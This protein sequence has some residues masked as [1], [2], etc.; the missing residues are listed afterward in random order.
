[1]TSIYPG[2]TVE[3]LA[4]I[5]R[6]LTARDQWILWRGA[7]RVDQK[8]GLITLNKIPINPQLLTNADSTDSAT[9]GTFAQCIAALPLAL[10]EW[11]T[12]DP[13]AFRGGGIGYVVSENDPY[14]GIDLDHCV[15]PDTGV[16]EPWAQAHVDALA[17][18]AEITPSGTGLHIWV[19][20]D[21]PPKGRKKGPI[22]MYTNARF[23]T[24]TGWHLDTTPVTCEPR[25]I[26]LT[27]LWCSIFGVQVGDTVWLVDEHGVI[28]NTPYNVP[29]TITAITAHT[30]GELY[31]WFAEMPGGWPA[32]QCERASPHPQTTP[33]PLCDDAVLK[34]KM[35]SATNGAKIRLLAQGLWQQTHS[36]QSEASL[37]FCIHCAFY[38]QDPAQI[39]RFFRTTGLM[40]PKW[41]EPRGSS[42]WGA[43]TITEALARQTEHYH[44]SLSSNG[45]HADPF[46]QNGT[47]MAPAPVGGVSVGDAW[48]TT[49][50]QLKI[51]DLAD[52]LDRQYPVPLW[53]I[54]DLIPEGLIFFIGSPKSSK[55]YLGYSL[56]LSLA[57][58]SQRG[59]TWLNHY[60]VEHSG[61]V[62]YVT[63]ED[64]EA[65]SRY[66]I[67]ELAP[68]MT[69]IA[70]DRLLFIHGYEFPRFD[71]GLVEVL[72]EQVFER[73]HPALVVLDPIS[74]LYSP[75]KKSGDQFAEVRD[76]LLPL[77]WMGR[78]YHATIAGVDHRRKKSADDVDI[79]ETQYGSVSKGAIADA[80]FVI[81][82]DDKEI[83]LH[84]RIR[85]AA[86][87]TLTL[88]FEFDQHGHATWTWKGSVDGL[89]GMGQY[90][91]LR[92]R[93]IEAI[94]GAQI[95]LSIPDILAGL[96]MPDSRQSRN[97]IYNI[98]FRAQKSHEV[99]KT[100]RGQYVWAGGS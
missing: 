79:F 64:D 75:M 25:Q 13:G 40:R 58:E 22:E 28:T 65:D 9:W 10:E 85:K 29:W 37:A 93:V 87:Q 94:S 36:S 49:L 66:R 48:K 19:Q 2:P 86:D 71:E 82:R 55:T 76:M 27:A 39:D 12:T 74:Y 61:P 11:E 60:P 16:I 32:M 89:V 72:R 54:K 77:R 41:D 47:T 14:A 91:D 35:L 30:T 88:G 90:G 42:T 31:A 80:M 99:Q 33:S 97:A 18:Y 26:A 15:H 38:T 43:G 81:V 63:L 46:A 51:T 45:A 23:F 21:L 20:G 7:D 3:N 84:A 1:M 6:E 69:T 100:T 34:A 62:V 53:L 67:A 44:G 57:Y 17:S 59:G 4:N 52:M 50:P 92:Q 95:P 96:S 56:A 78:E 5:P 24:M 98:L 73:Y 70:R 8:T 83:T 68:W